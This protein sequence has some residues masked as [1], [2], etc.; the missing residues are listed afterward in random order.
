MERLELYKKFIKNEIG[1]TVFEFMRVLLVNREALL[2]IGACSSEELDNILIEIQS[3]CRSLLQECAE[4][5]DPMKIQIN[6]I[7]EKLQMRWNG[8]GRLSDSSALVYL[9]DIMNK[10][11]MPRSQRAGGSSFG[12]LFCLDEDDLPF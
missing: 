4:I 9:E 1:Y 7:Y 8:L 3:E 11:T 10:D 2:K 5:D 12:E 6:M